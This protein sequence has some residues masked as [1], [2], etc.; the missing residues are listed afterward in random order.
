VTTA[1]HRTLIWKGH[2]VGSPRANRVPERIKEILA[3]LITTAKDPRIGFVTVT[4][5]RTT[6]DFS[7]ATVYYTVLGAPDDGSRPD[8]SPAHPSRSSG[9]P[10]SIAVVAGDEGEQ[11]R[12]EERTAEGLASASPMLRRELGR[13]LRL[14]QVPTLEFVHDPVPGHGRRIEALIDEAR[15]RR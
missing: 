1:A 12:A 13:R 8:R 15:G 2:I 4:D 6:A 10:S 11:A 3:G 5:V 7:H 14:R 9:E